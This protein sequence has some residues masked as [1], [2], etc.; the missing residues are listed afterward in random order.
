MP[1]PPLL[2]VREAARDLGV[3][4]TALLRAARVHGHLVQIGRAQRIPADE[5]GELIDKCRCPPEAR[6][7]HSG[8][9]AAEP[10]SGSSATPASQSAARARGIAARLKGSSRTTSRREGG[11]VVPIPPR[12]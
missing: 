2:T 7:S 12:R 10:R 4:E 3:P 11:E 1:L 9:A 5:L 6:A 8:D